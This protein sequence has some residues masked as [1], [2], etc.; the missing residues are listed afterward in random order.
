MARMMPFVMAAILAATPAVALEFDAGQ[1]DV[2]QVEEAYWR[3][4][5]NGDVDGYAA[6]FHENFVGWP[7]T[8]ETPKGTRDSAAW[9]KEIRDHRWALNYSLRP[10]AVQVFGDVAVVHYA[11]EYV[12]DYRNGTRRGEGDWRKFTHTWLKQGGRWLLIGGMCAD[13]KP[14]RS[15]LK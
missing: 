12:F 13:R 1:R 14:V 11:A 5:A 4:V 6:L 7:C 8:S 2:W 9:V 3:V 15:L 10:E